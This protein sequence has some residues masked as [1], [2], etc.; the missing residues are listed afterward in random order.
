MY[1]NI[2]VHVYVF[3]F[4][5]IQLASLKT[6]MNL[7]MVTGVRFESRQGEFHQLFRRLMLNPFL[8]GQLLYIALPVYDGVGCQVL[9]CVR[10]SLPLQCQGRACTSP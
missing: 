6:Q 9:A 4:I 7:Y 10:W 5:I 8:G 3:F 2:I 1:V